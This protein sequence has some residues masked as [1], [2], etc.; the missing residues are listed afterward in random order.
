MSTK[1]SHYSS[2]KRRG[3]PDGILGFFL[4]IWVLSLITCGIMAAVPHP[5]TV[6]NWI[7]FG[8]SAVFLVAILTDAV[9][10]RDFY[11]RRGY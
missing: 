10:R 9:L 7:A 4:V 1:S 5:S 2:K 3:L 6:G 8:A 11:S